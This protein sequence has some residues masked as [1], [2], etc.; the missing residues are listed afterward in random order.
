MTPESADTTS[1]AS[2][3]RGAIERMTWSGFAARPDTAILASGDGDADRLVCVDWRNAGARPGVRCEKIIARDVEKGDLA[4]QNGDG[5]DRHTDRPGVPAKPTASLDNQDDLAVRGADNL[6]NAAEH[7]VIVVEQWQTDEVAG[8]NILRETAVHSFFWRKTFLTRRLRLAMRTAGCA[9]RPSGRTGQRQA[10]SKEYGN[11]SHV[12]V[13][14][15][16]CH[17]RSRC[18]Q[19]LIRSTQFRPQ[20]E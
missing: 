10:H 12:T 8:P 17:S 15:T 7:A 18:N 20:V 9:S 1:K 2:R 13:S 3:D 11:Y 5:L 6:G 14:P 4:A 16:I 19:S